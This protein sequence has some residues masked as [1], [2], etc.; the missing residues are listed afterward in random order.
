[1]LGTSRFTAPRPAAAGCGNCARARERGG[2]LLAAL[3]VTMLAA[4]LLIGAAYD[5]TLRLRMRDKLQDGAMALV[6]A[7][8]GLENAQR[9]ASTDTT[10]TMTDSAPLWLSNK[11]V[12]RGA[13]SVTAID[14]G[15][16]F[17]APSGSDLSTSADTV[18]LTSTG[19][20]GTITRT[21]MAD[22]VRFPHS[23]LKQAVYS[24]TL[25]DLGGVTVEGRLRAH[26]AVTL[27]SACDVYGDITTLLGQTVTAALDDGDTDIFYVTSTLGMPAVD[28]VWYRNAGKRI[29]LPPSR[30]I[31]NKVYGPGLNPTGVASPEGIY[32][33]D[34]TGGTV[35]FKN[36]AVIGTLAVINATTVYIQDTGGAPT[37]YYQEPADPQR[38]PAL[39]VQGNLSMY[40]EGSSY[41][42]S[43]LG[44]P[45]TKTCGIQGVI[46]CTGTF[47][48]PQLNAT[49]PGSYDGTIIANE[50]HLRGPGTL[51][52][53]DENYNLDPVAGLTL[54]GL[55]LIPDT[56]REM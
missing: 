55:R 42:F 56:R 22:Y 7:Q 5:A 4:T 21:L 16:G 54:S 13:A 51:I 1:V 14:P 38:M 36:V 3:L 19:Q 47:W 27:I 20:V 48:G 50:V 32:W 17:M 23:A 45:Y 49:L 34:A 26:G 44:T 11:A 9:M 24:R 15:D 37:T 39:L 10:F 53:H 40:I 18:R 35:E 31:S 29:T 12:G 8:A 25:L 30:K 2:I 43:V 28:F 41:S 33:I 46:Y 52:R 6:C